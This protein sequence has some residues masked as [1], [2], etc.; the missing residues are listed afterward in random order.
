MTRLLPKTLFGQTLLVLLFPAALYL[1]SFFTPEEKSGI[2]SIF[3]PAQGVVK[4]WD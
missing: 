4:P 1:M 2:A 3:R